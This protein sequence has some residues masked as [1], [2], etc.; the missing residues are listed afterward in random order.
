MKKID[1]VIRKLRTKK[2]LDLF[3]SAFVGNQLRDLFSKNPKIFTCRLLFKIFNSGMLYIFN[4]KIKNK[5][6]HNYI[7][8]NFKK[9][10]DHISYYFSICENLSENNIK[11]FISNCGCLIGRIVNPSEELQIL[12]VK[13]NYEAI[14]YIK[15]P[16]KLIE[17]I[18]IKSNP[19]SIMFIK[20]PSETCQLY[21]VY[22]NPEL[23]KNIRIPIEDVQLLALQKNI[24]LLAFTDKN[25]VKNHLKEKGYSDYEI[26]NFYMLALNQEEIASMLL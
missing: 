23:I 13:N 26:K 4:I 16:S 6:V 12:A 17:T 7:V 19:N 14:R 11:K 3:N 15:N 21:A 9:D 2:I 20:E 24:K 22:K 18:A 8:N 1:R 5:D 10:N 25:I